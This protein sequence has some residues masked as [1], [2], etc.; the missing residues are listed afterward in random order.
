[1]SVVSRAELLVSRLLRFLV[2]ALMIGAVLINFT[3]VVGRYAFLR[4]FVWA[5]EVMQFLNIWVVMLGAAL[6][7]RNG[8]HLKMD[9]LY[10]MIGPRARRVLDAVANLLTVAV[11]LY[12]VIQSVHMVRMLTATGQRSV[13]ARI[14]MNAMYAAIPLG[15]AVAILFLA[16]WFWRVARGQPAPEAVQADHGIPSR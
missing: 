15:F 13:I 5:E 12:V 2:G 1:M 16:L 3:N 8:A 6:V 11:S 14:P 4:P 9:A 7:A 10:A